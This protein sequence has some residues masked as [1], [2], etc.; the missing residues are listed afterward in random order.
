VWRPQEA[1][2]CYLLLVVTNTGSIFY[3]LNGWTAALGAWILFALVVSLLALTVMGRRFEVSEGLV[4]AALVLVLV[5]ATVYIVGTANQRSPRSDN[6]DALEIGF[7][8]LVQG[9]DPYQATTYAGNPITPGLGGIILAGPV[10][11]ILG[12]LALLGLVWLFAMAAGLR[13][14][15]GNRAALAFL[16]LLVVSP[17]MLLGWPRQYDYWINAAALVLFGSFGM[18]AAERRRTVWVYAT[19]V[20]FRP[21]DG[22]PPLQTMGA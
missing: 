22:L 21:G 10:L 8:R 1:V 13:S 17:L 14:L 11:L 9:L 16:T 12:S 3:S 20:L 2:A 5:L 4:G 18:R 7:H 6:G 19:A 15:G